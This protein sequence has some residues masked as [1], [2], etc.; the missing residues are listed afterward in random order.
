LSAAPRRR[1]LF[2]LAGVLTWALILGLIFSDP[3][4]TRPG[5]LALMAVLLIW[6]TRVAVRGWRG[7]ALTA[8]DTGVRFRGLVWTRS[9]RWQLIGGFVAETRP[10]RS[11]WLPVRL[12]QLHGS[13]PG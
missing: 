1:A 13:V 12:A 4:G 5:D 3:D 8:T 10:V 9:W 2:P 7:A 11:T 6:V